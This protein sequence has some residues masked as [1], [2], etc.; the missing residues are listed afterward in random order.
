MGGHAPRV[1]WDSSGTGELASDDFGSR[2]GCGS[3]AGKLI[4]LRRA[5]AQ[6]KADNDASGGVDRRHDACGSARETPPV[7]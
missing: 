4:L 2:N 3:A 5:H 1:A 7:R 6:N